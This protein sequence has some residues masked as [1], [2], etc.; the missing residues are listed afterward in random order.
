[1][2]ELIRE[3]KKKIFQK[4][5]NVVRNFK[6]GHNNYK[7]MERNR[8]KQDDKRSKKKMETTFE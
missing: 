5:I 4:N 7:H 1:M 3:S 2:D 8:T 6:K